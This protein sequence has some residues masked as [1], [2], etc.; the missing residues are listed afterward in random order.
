MIS[1]HK[2]MPIIAPSRNEEHLPNYPQA[3]ALPLDLPVE[4]STKKGFG[5]FFVLG[6]AAVAAWLLHTAPLVERRTAAGEDW[7]RL[8][9]GGFRCGHPA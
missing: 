9:H 1:A 2:S 7:R 5:A 6:A 3:G 8:G 4:R